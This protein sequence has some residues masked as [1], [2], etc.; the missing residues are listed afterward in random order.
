MRDR[1]NPFVAREGIPFL[2][3]AVVAIFAV[4]QFADLIFTL[5]PAVVLVWLFLVFR[6]PVRAIPAVPLGV[7]SPVDGT[8]VEVGL[9]DNGALNGE[10]HRIL[11][12]VELL[13]TYTARCPTEGKI[14]DFRA[15]VPESAAVGRA[16]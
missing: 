10:A 14:M 15:A 8:V 13:G 16:T 7:L 9:T 1:D 12:K 5:I 11:I 2:V 3:A 6:D 4:A